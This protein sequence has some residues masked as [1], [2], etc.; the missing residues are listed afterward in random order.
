MK[1]QL[2][3]CGWCLDNYIKA[4]NCFE[5]RK[6]I[7]KAKKLLCSTDFII[8]LQNCLDYVQEPSHYKN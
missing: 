5:Q 2:I 1:T 3:T 7:E 6:A 4:T 8:F